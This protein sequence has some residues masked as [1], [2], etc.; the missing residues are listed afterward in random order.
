MKPGITP[1]LWFDKEAE[2]AANFYVSVFPNSKIG[3]ITRYPDA[4]QEITGGTPGSVLTV[5]FT[6]NGQSIVGINGGPTFKPNEAVS[7][8][9]T[10]ETQEEIDELWAK[11][12]ADGGSESQC[13]WLKDKYGFSWQIIP[14]GVDALFRDPDKSKCERAMKA[15]LKMKK[16][17]IE[18]L[19]KAAAGA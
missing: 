3:S 6:V 15:M 11:L 16:L 14:D 18:A 13:G 1:N 19:K 12:T 5:E 10:C 4:G 17:D 2:E 8:M 7:L 9:I